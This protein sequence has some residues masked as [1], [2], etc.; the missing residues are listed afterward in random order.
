MA[1]K[2][3]LYSAEQIDE[4]NQILS[5]T[6]K[7]FSPGIVVINNRKEPFSQLSDSPNIPRFVDTKIVAMGDPKDFT[8]RMPEN[9]YRSKE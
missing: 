3:F 7:K 4:K 9:V 2:Y 6:S 8:Y 1:L 5:K